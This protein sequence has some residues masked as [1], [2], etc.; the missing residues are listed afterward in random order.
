[1]NRMIWCMLSDVRAG[2]VGFPSSGRRLPLLPR[3][4][5][6]N[7]VVALPIIPHELF[8]AD[9][10]GCLEEVVGEGREFICNECRTTVPVADV[11]RAVMEMESA[12]ATCPHCGRLNHIDGFSRIDAFVCRYCGRGGSV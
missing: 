4:M 12:D 11:Q 9:C 2:R 1:M 8:G 7:K 3:G 6:D 5:T 10:C